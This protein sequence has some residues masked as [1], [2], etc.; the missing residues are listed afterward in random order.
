M[1][2][3]LF[4][5][6]DLV[7][8]HDLCA[9]INRLLQSGGGVGKGSVFVAVDAVFFGEASVFESSEEFGLF[10]GH[11]ATLAEGGKGFFHDDS[12]PFVIVMPWRGMKKC[13]LEKPWNMREK[14]ILF[15]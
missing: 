11:T 12:H 15:T 14:T 2:T 10:H 8:C 13:F 3:G 5:G 9:E 7:L 4:F 1:L 6:H